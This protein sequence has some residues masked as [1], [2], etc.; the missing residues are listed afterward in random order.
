MKTQVGAAVVHG[1]W[2]RYPLFAAF[3]LLLLT[4]LTLQAREYE[5]EQQ[6]ISQFFPQATQISEPAGE[7]Q[8]R[9]L[10]D[11]AGSVLGYA[12]QSIHV[13]DM[14]A[15]SGKPINMQILLDPAGVIVDAYMLEHHEPIVLIGIPEKKVHD[16]NAHY[17]GIKADQR[18]VVG[19]SS[20][21]SAVTIDAVTGATVTVMVINEIVMRAAHTVAVD[22]GLVAAGASA[23]PK[24]ALVRED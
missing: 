12:F 11:D 21:Q 18:V 13:T 14:P 3:L 23:R 10:A 5:A 22:L 9:T 17:G 4:S 2:S 24:I 8:V 6:R 16:F 7:Y 1:S 19:R 20:D 15:Y